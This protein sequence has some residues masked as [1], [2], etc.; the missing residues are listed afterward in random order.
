MTPLHEAAERG[1]FKICKLL[2]RNVMDKNPQDAI[3]KTPLHRAAWTGNLKLAELLR[4]ESGEDVHWMNYFQRLRLIF[5]IL[6]GILMF[7]ISYPTYFLCV[8]IGLVFI[9]IFEIKLP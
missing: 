1:H 9:L 7:Y 2:I 6:G 4:K 8:E 5:E 3:G